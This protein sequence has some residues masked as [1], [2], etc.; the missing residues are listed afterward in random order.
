MLFGVPKP[1]GTT[2]PIL[3]LSDR[4]GLSH[5]INELLDEELCTVEHAQLKECVEIVNA[6]GP[7]AFLWAKDLKDGYYNVSVYNLTFIIWDFDLMVESIFFNDCPR[8]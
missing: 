6:L 1:D 3:N 8:D 2:R 7:D 4:K 5:C